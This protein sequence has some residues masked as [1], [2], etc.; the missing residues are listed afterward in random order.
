MRP[1]KVKTESENESDKNRPLTHPW[2]W[3]W[4]TSEND[5]PS[6]RES[7]KT[8]HRGLTK[9]AVPVCLSA[10]PY[11]SGNTAVESCM[12]PVQPPQYLLRPKMGVLVFNSVAHMIIGTLGEI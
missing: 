12:S 7:E 9:C 10:Y 6:T 2:K 5:W 8:H 1:V 11:S 4:I 3:K